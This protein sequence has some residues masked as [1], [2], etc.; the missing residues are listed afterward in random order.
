[1]QYGTSRIC[2]HNFGN[3]MMQAEQIQD[4]SKD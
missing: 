1:M 3:K 2:I 4:G